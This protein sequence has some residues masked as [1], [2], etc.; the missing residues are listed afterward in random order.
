MASDELAGPDD[1]GAGQTHVTS[2]DYTH[3]EFNVTSENGTTTDP[4]SALAEPEYDVSP[5]TAS[6][7]A[8][9]Y[10]ISSFRIDPELLAVDKVRGRI[11]FRRP[12]SQQWFRVL[13]KPGF[14]VDAFTFDHEEDGD[15]VTYLVHRNAHPFL[16]GKDRPCRLYVC[17]TR[18]GVL[19]LWPAKLPTGG[20]GQTWAESGLA[21]AEA[22]KRQWVMV[23]GN[24]RTGAYDWSTPRGDLGEP[25]WPD[26]TL[27]DIVEG[28]T[29][30]YYITGPDHP[31]V[32]ALNGEM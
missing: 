26:L 28:A 25:D 4:A 20:Q 11:P 27:R 32:R 16:N 19:H 15:K 23:E 3:E 2:N 18:Y 9:P 6:G 24:K 30:G 5:E 17:V 31:V 1:I 14:S 21:V 10:D 12:S 8:D 13:A 22:A 7:A 29:K